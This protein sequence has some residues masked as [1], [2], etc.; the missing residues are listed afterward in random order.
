MKDLKHPIYFAS[1]L[2]DANNELVKQAAADGKKALGYT[3]YFVPEV[4]LNLPGCFSV[5]L[6]APGTGS[7]D[8]GAQAAKAAALKHAGLSEGQVQELQVEW[9]SEHGRAVYE[10]EFKSGGMEYEY[11]IDAATGAVLN[12]ETERDD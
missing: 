7:T 4:L 5:R 8:I 10:V 2:A 6:R 11:V 3:C 9:D 12:H 1:L